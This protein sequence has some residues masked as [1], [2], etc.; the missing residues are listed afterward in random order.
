MYL[1]FR[2]FISALQILLFILGLLLSLATLPAFPFIHSDEVWLADLSRAMVQ[3]GNPAA[4]ESFFHLTPRY[5]HAIKTL[6]H[7][8]QG[9]FLKGSF[10]P[11]AARLPSFLAG[12]LAL[13]AT[14]W[15]AK[16][17]P[18]LKNWWVAVPLFLLWNLQ[19]FYASHFGRQEI[20]L[21][22]LFMAGYGILK[23]TF[24]G[25]KQGVLLGLVTAPGIFIHPNSFIIALSLGFM[26]VYRDISG[27][28]SKGVPLRQKAAGWF[29]YTGILAIAAAAALRIS[30]TWDPD[31][32]IHY[33]DFGDN[34][35]AALPLFLK[36]RRLPLFFYKMYI[37]A[38]GTYYLPP[39]KGVMIVGTAALILRPLLG[40]LTKTSRPLAT[41][42][43]TL[44]LTA[45]LTLIGK[46]SPPSLVF[47]FPLAAFALVETLVL[48][49]QL[50]IRS[51]RLRILSSLPLILG[52]A[53][54]LLQAGS[55][56]AEVRRTRDTAV[57][58]RRYE[59]F[60]SEVI[61]PNAKVLANLNTGFI[62]DSRRIHPFRDL[63]F[64][65]EAGI[66]VIEYLR[67][68]NI[69][70]VVWPE[71]MEI[72]YAERPV[73]NDLYGNLYPYYEDLFT[74][75]QLSETVATAIFPVYGMRIIPYQGRRGGR[76]TVHRLYLP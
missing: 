5:P 4:T 44:G 32:F 25:W 7:L 51:G 18:D 28:D 37:R 73:W 54:F 40:F 67:R 20:F 22:A 23:N 19:F 8:I 62:L 63:A 70:W 69:Q 76:V 1:K 12:L 17:T 34:T 46:Y 56:A 11:L 27:R 71:E 30:L 72:I 26:L 60:I 75:L 3:S 57:E 14:A 39:L 31:F 74:L 10:T 52:T 68:E 33:R 49:N 6:Y 43:G 36:L 45:G 16:K 13:A 59:Q 15:A 65:D 53:L 38:A 47:F 42:A 21:L 55:T 58:Y 41:T 24:P 48:M 50:L 9:L 2:T 35:G 64:L 61:P 66:T 29:L